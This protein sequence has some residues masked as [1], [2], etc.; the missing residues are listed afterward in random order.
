VLDAASRVALALLDGSID[1]HEGRRWRAVCVTDQS[2]TRKSDA[3][4]RRPR[5]RV[6]DR[7]AIPD[8]AAASGQYRP[9][10]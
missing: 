8:A 2:P 1:L 9:I 5:S 10:Y 7:S 4:V 6:V 3:A